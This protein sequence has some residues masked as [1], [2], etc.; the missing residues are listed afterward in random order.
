[1]YYFVSEAVSAGHP[2]KCAD[3]IAD[4][5]VDR[6]LQLD[7]T[8]K[9]ATE[10]FIS[11]KHII[12]G[13][14]VKTAA[15]VDTSFYEEIAREALKQIGYPEIGFKKDET[16]FPDE[17][18]IEVY[19]SRQSPDITMGV[20]KEDDE[21]GA[22]DQGMIFGYATSEREDCM[23]TAFSYAR[24]IR[25]VLYQYALKNPKIFGVDIKTEIVMDY[26][27]KE[28]FDN[29]K[30]QRIAKIIVAIPHNSSVEAEEVQVLVKK[31]IAEEV[32]F[33][34]GHFNEDSIVFYINNTGRYVTHSPIADSGLTG[35][36][37]VCDTYGSYAPIG[38]GAQSSKDY[39]KVDRSALYAARWLAKHIVAAGL[40]KKALVQLSYVIAEARPIAV[41][42][43]TQHTSLIKMKDEELS[44]I[45]AD[46][47]SLSPKWIMQKFHLN[48]P[49]KESFLYA[50]IAAKGQV[51]YAQYP[52]EQ[53]DELNWFKSL[54]E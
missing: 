48:K 18:D 35:R 34:A 51:G 28:N 14:E 32:N 3:I 50:D 4:S 8:A 33:K 47:F 11:G 49:S 20:V 29:C 27:S 40:A 15:L 25:D 26:G 41:T 37:V 30:P 22:G 54:K 38:G 2:D 31:I 7:S 53:L 13:G 17:T 21:I 52:W 10:V 45:I 12:I 5:I 46:K 16:L 23:P 39:S 1:M 36:K 44:Q 9:V 19:I 24:Q 42:V 43:D 6:L